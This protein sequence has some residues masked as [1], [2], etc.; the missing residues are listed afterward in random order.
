MDR[1]QVDLGNPGVD[2]R[3]GEADKLRL[4]GPHIHC[5]V[6]AVGMRNIWVFVSFQLCCHCFQG[7]VFQ[8]TSE[9]NLGKHFLRPA[10]LPS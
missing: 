7:A 8:N 5:C 9:R 4:T 3:Q 2:R 1:E 10:P 6:L